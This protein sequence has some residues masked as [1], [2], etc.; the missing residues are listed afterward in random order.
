[1]YKDVRTTVLFL[2]RLFRSGEFNCLL[3]T[4]KYHN[5]RYR[6]RFS[7]C[8]RFPLARSDLPSPTKRGKRT[9]S[10]RALA[11]NCPKDTGLSTAAKFAN[12]SHYTHAYITYRNL[13]RSTVPLLLE[14]WAVFFHARLERALACD[15]EK[16]DREQRNRAH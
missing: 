6:R 15:P 9:T 7:R 12:L 11:V 4:A 8:T 16:V 1:V 13:I 3:A 2:L 10:G 5:Y 14:F